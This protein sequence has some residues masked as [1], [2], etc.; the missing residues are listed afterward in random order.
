MISID[1]I[2]ADYDAG[3]ISVEEACRKLR[4]AGLAA[5][6][7]T[8]P[9]HTPEA[10]RYRILCPTSKELPVTERKA[11]VARMNGVMGA[12]WTVPR[13]RTRRQCLSAM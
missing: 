6:L 10:P 11:L 1:G 5:L 9:S 3:K 8:T 13:S 7:C 2:E 4:E 12:F